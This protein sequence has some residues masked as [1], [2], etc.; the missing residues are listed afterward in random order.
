MEDDLPDFALNG[1]GYTVK[2]AKNELKCIEM[3]IRTLGQNLV[4]HLIY[5]YT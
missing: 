5:K 2:E 3:G 1:Q 4:L